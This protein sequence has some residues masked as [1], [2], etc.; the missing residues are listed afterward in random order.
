M[1][2]LLLAAAGCAS[3][4]PR[5]HVRVDLP[6]PDKGAGS[7]QELQLTDAVRGAADAEGLV[8]QPGTGAALLRCTA[9]AVGNQSSGVTIGL[10]RSG[11]GY[12]VSID[13]PFHLPGSSSPVCRVQRRVS[14]QIDSALQAPLARVDTRSDCKER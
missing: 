1:A 11:T 2:V 6:G 7:P 14:D 10:A 13:Q 4:A 9:A 3:G 5:G 8:C 12:E